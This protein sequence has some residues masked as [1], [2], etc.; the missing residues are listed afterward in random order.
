MAWQLRSK[1]QYG[2]LIILLGMTCWACATHSGSD[3]IKLTPTSRGCASPQQF[4]EP[5]PPAQPPA[6]PLPAAAAPAVTSSSWTLTMAER[7][8]SANAGISETLWTAA[9]PPYGQYDF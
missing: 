4:A 9:R 3:C 2:G 6:V 7:P 1:G 8:V 5:P